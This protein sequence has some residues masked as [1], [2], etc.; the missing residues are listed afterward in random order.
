MR[1]VF[2]LSA[3]SIAL[4]SL[5]GWVRHE[6]HRSATIMEGSSDEEYALFVG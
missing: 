5:V 6:S 2:L 1:S 4:L 3:V